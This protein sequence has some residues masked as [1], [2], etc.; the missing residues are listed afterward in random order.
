MKRSTVFL[1]IAS[2]L[3]LSIPYSAAAMDDL[4]LWNDFIEQIKAGKFTEDMIRP[5]FES[6]RKSNMAFINKMKNEALRQEL[7]SQPE[8]IRANNR[9]NYLLA[10]T[11]NNS[12]NTYCFTFIEENGKAYLQHIETIF[13]RLDKIPSLP[14]SEF[15][16]VSDSQKAWARE[17]IY[18]SEQVRL[19]NYLSK[20]KGKEF[21]FDWFK[22]GAGYFLGAKTWV[23]FVDPKKAFILYLCWEQ[24]NLRGSKVVLE[25]LDEGE[26]IVKIRP[27][28][29][30][31]Y[32]QSSHLR[33]QISWEDYISLFFTIWQERAEKAGWK[34]DFKLGEY[35][36]GFHFT[37]A[38]R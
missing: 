23:P 4:K 8:I 31:I 36:I 17:E 2:F 37:S 35:L 33:Q 18:W 12:Q 28:L 20:E 19:F 34:L 22:D 26:A 11:F 15:P 29:I 10:L 25:K 13:V 27:L 21:A 7:E 14:A 1:F 24:A 9:I 38:G 16:D 32:L 6:L 30:N 3:L 5:H